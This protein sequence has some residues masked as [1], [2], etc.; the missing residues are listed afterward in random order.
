MDLQKMS[1]LDVPFYGQ[2]L[3]CDCDPKLSHNDTDK[4]NTLGKG[5]HLGG[6]RLYSEWVWGTELSSEIQLA[7]LSQKKFL[8]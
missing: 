8:S 7:K 5:E 3:R 2:Q 4:D 1:N 6:S